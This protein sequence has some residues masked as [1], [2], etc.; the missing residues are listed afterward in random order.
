MYLLDTDILSALRKVQRNR[1]VVAW[2]KSVNPD[3]V[4]VSAITVME[5]ERGIEKERRT[6]PP[7]ALALTAWLEASLVSFGP[8]VL[9]VTTPIARRW[10]RIQIQLGRTDNDI[11]IAATALEHNLQVVTRNVRHFNTT[12]VVII[13]PF[14]AA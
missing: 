13:N 12:G 14:D 3:D 5:I 10:G 8:R 2:L 7:L 9:E 1:K 6:N 4:F 11:P